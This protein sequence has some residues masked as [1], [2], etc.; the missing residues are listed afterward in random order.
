M[1]ACH[2][3]ANKQVVFFFVAII[4]RFLFCECYRRASFG[5][6]VKA[7]KTATGCGGPLIAMHLSFGVDIVVFKTRTAGVFAAVIAVTLLAAG[8]SRTASFVH[9]VP[10]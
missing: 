8:S 5:S 6:V 10:L 9:R 3:A 1:K 7:K 2:A 4:V